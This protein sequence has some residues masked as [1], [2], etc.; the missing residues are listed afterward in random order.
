MAQGQQDRGVNPFSYQAEDDLRARKAFE[1]A[2]ARAALAE[3]PARYHRFI[4]FMERRQGFRKNGVSYSNPCPKNALGWLTILVP[5]MNCTGRIEMAR[6]EHRE[7]NGTLDISPTEF[8]ELG[9]KTYCRGTVTSSIRGSASAVARAFFSGGP[10]TD[11]PGETAETSW[12]GRALRFLG[13]GNLAGAAEGATLPWPG[14]GPAFVPTIGGRRNGHS[15]PQ[16]GRQQAN[17]GS[18]GQPPLETL[19]ALVEG[20]GHKSDK[21]DIK[22]AFPE[23]L[24]DEGMLARDEEGEL[25]VSDLS[26]ETIAG[27]CRK[28]DAVNQRFFVFRSVLASCRNLEIDPGSLKQFCKELK[29]ITPHENGSYPWANLAPGV[30]NDIMKGKT[31]LVAA[32]HKWLGEF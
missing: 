25:F 16:G 3:L 26:E 9:D 32:Y 12:L 20:L 28:F 7:Q 22:K 29:H 15:G 8:F 23:F 13:Y 4:Q 5:E 30:A 24:E 14:R 1:E 21:E 27:L 2:A 6:D 31:E 18:G 19:R 10:H 17:G 11:Y